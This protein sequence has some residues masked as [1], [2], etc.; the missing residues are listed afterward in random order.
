MTD[1]DVLH[2]VPYCHR[3]THAFHTREQYAFILFA[4]ARLDVPCA[5]TRAMCIDTDRTVRDL[6]ACSVHRINELLDVLAQE[7]DLIGGANAAHERLR[8]E[9]LRKEF[10]CHS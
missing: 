4:A 3:Q 10:L 8:K 9:R 2:H 5:L 6:E 1:R 7:I